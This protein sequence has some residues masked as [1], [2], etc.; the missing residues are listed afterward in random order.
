[1]DKRNFLLGAAPAVGL[2]TLVSVWGDQNVDNQRV[3]SAS[4]A[5]VT[6][7]NGGRHMDDIP[8]S[9]DAKI[10][11]E[12]REQIVLIG[13]NRPQIFNRIDPEAFYGLARAYYD[14]D[15]DSTLRAAVLFGH[16]DHFS[17][18]NDVEAF[19]AL[20][21]SG[22]SFKLGEGQ[23]DPLGRAQRLSKPL[24]VVVHGDTWN[25][26]HELYLAADIR[27]ANA[28]VRYG[29]NENAHGRVPG[30]APVRFVREAGWANAMR[31]LLTGDYWDAQTAYRMGIVQEVAPD[32]SAALKL[33]ID[34]ANRVAAC[35]PLGIK[36]T[37]KVAHLGINDSADAAAFAELEREYVSLFKS[38][39]FIEGRRAEA[40]NRPPIFHGR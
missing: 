23:I 24:V 25:M 21:K 10:T 31:Y 3:L 29:Q 7:P 18:G 28:D 17:R 15:I 27:V 38:E 2:S 40:E 1:V 33:G 9:A 13:I 5:G 12:R 39:D 26:G 19:S 22:Q 36:A 6:S 34:I 16:G 37:L 8:R 32:K 30:T 14:F 35:G 4:Q 11:V 20:A